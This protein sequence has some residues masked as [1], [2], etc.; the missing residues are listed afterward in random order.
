M[1]AS[2]AGARDTDLQALIAERPGI[3]PALDA[4][5]DL[6]PALLRQLVSAKLRDNNVIS[7]AYKHVDGTSF[8]APIVASVAAQMIEA[9]P[10]LTPQEAKGILIRTARR[11]PHVETDRQG[12]GV[13]DPRKAV[14]EAVRRRA[15]ADLR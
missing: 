6:D 5:R 14:E 10:G 8:A 9:N 3:D 1:L 13:V 15:G 11:L 2:L 12:W 4:A 7:G